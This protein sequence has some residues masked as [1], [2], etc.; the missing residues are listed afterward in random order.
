MKLKKALVFS[1]N[2]DN[3]GPLCSGANFLAEESVAAVLAC[4]ECAESLL[5]KANKV[6]WLGRKAE[7]SDVSV[8]KVNPSYSASLEL[9]IRQCCDP[10]PEKRIPDMYGVLQRLV[11]IATCS[12]REYGKL[13]KNAE[14]VLPSNVFGY[15]V[16]CVRRAGNSIKRLVQNRLF[17][18]K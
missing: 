5:T 9:V 15:T 10:D 3:I 12:P 14:N 8:R 16:L 17:F 11:D 6:A 18:R 13:E 1:A 7:G 4:R 2:Y